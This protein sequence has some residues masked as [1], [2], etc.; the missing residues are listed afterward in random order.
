MSQ[1]EIRSY[2]TQLIAAVRGG[3]VPDGRNA[4]FR[5]LVELISGSFAIGAVTC[6]ERARIFGSGSIDP[7]SLEGFI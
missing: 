5:M 6:C 3:H 7:L 1:S 4:N 2:E